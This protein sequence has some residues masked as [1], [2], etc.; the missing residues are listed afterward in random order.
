MGGWRGGGG[1][2]ESSGGGG[3]GGGGRGS[4]ESSVVELGY[5]SLVGRFFVVAGPGGQVFWGFFCGR[6]GVEFRISLGL[7]GGEREKLFS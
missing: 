1:S 4:C 3:G 2:C 6:R 7:R 5:V